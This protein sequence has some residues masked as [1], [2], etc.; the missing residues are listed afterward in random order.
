[1]LF[2]K[3][4]LRLFFR[5]QVMLSP[6]ATL[7]SWLTISMCIHSVILNHKTYSIQNI[8]G[9]KSVSMIHLHFHLAELGRPITVWR[10]GSSPLP[11][12]MAGRRQNTQVRLGEGRDSWSFLQGRLC[13]GAVGGEEVGGQSAENSGLQKL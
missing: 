8:K 13:A 9:N 2:S 12:G 1:M 4:D 5:L 6:R 7:I 11:G 3:E 10:W